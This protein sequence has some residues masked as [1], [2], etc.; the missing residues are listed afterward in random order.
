[1]T[2]TRARARRRQERRDDRGSDQNSGGGGHRDHAGRAGV[3]YE[4]G[5]DPRERP[6][7][8]RADGDAQAG[9]PDPLAQHAGQDIPGRRSDGH[10]N[11]EFAR[12]AA[13]RERK[14]SGDADDRDGERD[15]GES[16]FDPEA[17]QLSFGD[18]ARHGPGLIVDYR[19]AGG[20]QFIAWVE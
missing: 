13:H 20:G 3:A 2:S 12:A 14:H 10:A 9:D 1:M 8:E 11:P 7:S 16:E 17:I 18:I 15:G 6:A 4:A 5:H 19:H